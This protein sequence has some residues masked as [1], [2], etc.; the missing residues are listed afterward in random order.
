MSQKNNFVKK[1][2]I[3]RTLVASALIANGVFQFVAPVLAEGTAAGRTISNTAEATYEDPN[4][5]GV[6]INATSNTVTVTVAE[7]AGITVVSSGTELKIDQNNDTK[8]NVGDE[9][10]YNY[11]VTNVGNDPTKFRIPN[12]PTINGPGQIPA[13]QFVQ[14]SVDGGANYVD[15]NNA[16]FETQS[17]PAGGQVLVRVPVRVTNAANTGDAIRLF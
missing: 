11:T 4:N 13:G 9:I 8:L 3:Y 2:R 1:G 5:P 7:V 14:V 6:P 10:Y 16:T 12:A 17:I 15:V